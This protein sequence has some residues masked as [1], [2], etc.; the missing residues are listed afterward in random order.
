MG[1][2]PAAHHRFLI[3]ALQ[4]TA[5]GKVDRF[6]TPPAAAS[7]VRVTDWYKFCV[8]G[9]QDPLLV[10]HRSLIVPIMTRWH[11]DDLAGR[12]LAEPDPTRGLDCGYSR[13][14]AE[15][16]SDIKLARRTLF[17]HLPPRRPPA[18]RS[19]TT[20]TVQ[21]TR[22]RFRNG[23]APGDRFART[24][25]MLAASDTTELAARFGRGLLLGGYLKPRQPCASRDAG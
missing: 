21:K 20:R 1:L 14:N 4:E 15:L 16:S 25:N 3:Q 10:T 19:A 2:K 6:A 5:E 8:R 7:R 11:E 13:E 9:S 18:R 17:R 22:S 24:R 12:L 23:N